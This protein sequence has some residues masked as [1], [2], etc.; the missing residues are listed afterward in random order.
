MTDFIWFNYPFKMRCRCFI[1]PVAF[2]GITSI[3]HVTQ[4]A[5]LH[6]MKEFVVDSSPRIGSMRTLIVLFITFIKHA[7]FIDLYIAGEWIPASF[8]TFL[9]V[10]I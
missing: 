3:N 4:Q 5:L 10:F 9:T 2:F 7:A 6:R 1:K 8:I